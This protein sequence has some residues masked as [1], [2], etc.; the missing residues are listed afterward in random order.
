M[1]Q[2]VGKTELPNSD[3]EQYVAEFLQTWCG[4]CKGMP[5][6]NARPCSC[7]R[8]E[9]TYREAAAVMKVAFLAGFQKATEQ[10]IGEMEGQEITVSKA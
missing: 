4:I 1:S 2:P 5:M 10:I 8:S 3:A 6:D 9:R 7:M